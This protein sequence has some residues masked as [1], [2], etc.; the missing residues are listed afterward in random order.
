MIR[1]EAEDERRREE[2]RLRKITE[3]IRRENEK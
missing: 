3:R 2:L 1:Q